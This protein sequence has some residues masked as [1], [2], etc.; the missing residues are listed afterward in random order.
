MRIF[1]GTTYRDM[2]SEEIAA[3]TY[4]PTAHE[5]ITALKQKLAA[6]DYKAIKFAEG[7]L[8]AAEYNTTKLQRQEWR[9]QI[10]ALEAQL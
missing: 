10:N 5:K 4:T 3:A 2:T 9:A 1:D 7:L 8:T 6:T